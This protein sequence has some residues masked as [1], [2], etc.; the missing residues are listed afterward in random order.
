MTNANIRIFQGSLESKLEINKE[1]NGIVS[2]CCVC[3]AGLTE[4]NLPIYYTEVQQE[5]IKQKYD[6]SHG[7]C[8][9]CIS[10]EMYKMEN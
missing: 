5:Q 8:K 9:P 4:N 6:I 3:K 1:I 2:M 10:I 7:Y